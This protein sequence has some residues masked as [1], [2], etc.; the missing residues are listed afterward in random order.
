[1][2]GA[3]HVCRSESELRIAIA[4]K[5]HHTQP[6]PSLHTSMGDDEMS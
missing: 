1:M 2:S 6:L 5:S 3:F 4:H